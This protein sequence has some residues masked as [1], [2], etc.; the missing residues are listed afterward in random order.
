MP[1]HASFLHPCVYVGS[2]SCWMFCAR[3]FEVT[4]LLVAWVIVMP[5]LGLDALGTAVAIG[6][7]PLLLTLICCLS[8]V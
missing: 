8:P 1:V 2:A 3:N 7:E 4:L 6:L 5:R